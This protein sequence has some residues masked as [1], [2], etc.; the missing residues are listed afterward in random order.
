MAISESSR[1][2]ASLRKENV[3]VQRLIVNQV[4][5]PSAVDCKFCA[6]RR[7]VHLLLAL[8]LFMIRIVV[9]KFVTLSL[10]T[11]PLFWP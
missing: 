8:Y 3:P 7:K 11:S 6:M 9:L 10:K 4:L 5:T 2:R 1:L